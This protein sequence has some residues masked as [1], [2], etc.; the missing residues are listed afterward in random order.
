M[1]PLPYIFFL[2]CSITFGQSTMSLLF[3]GD[4]MGH[5][6]QIEAAFDPSKNDYSYDAVFSELREIISKPDFA[7]ANLEVTLA[8][9]PYSG[10]PQFSSPDALAEACKENGI[11]IL[12]TSNNHSCDRGGKGIKRTIKVLDRL[13]IPHNGTYVNA[14]DRK[15]R[16]LLI[17]RKN[18]LR[19]GLL[20]Y[21][22]GTNGLKAPQPTNVNYIDTNQIRLDIEQSKNESLDGLIAI[23]HWGKEYQTSPNKYQIKIAEFLLR[24]GVNIIIGSHPHVLQKVEWNKEKDQL[25][26]YSLGNFVSNQASI[27]TDGGMMLEIELEK[28]NE[29]L[30]IKNAGY[31]LVWVNKPTRL[32]KKLFEVLPCSSYPAIKQI[33][34]PAHLSKMKIFMESARKIMSSNRNVLEINPAKIKK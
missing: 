18:D 6:S 27:N 28:K 21:T 10:Y 19:I 31:H 29:A 11:D 13:Q 14:V 26:A 12:V 33:K 23:V 9:P 7:I 20:N 15:L 8:G 34:N 22:Y 16:N 32:N 17:L 1:K 25:V 2:T 30:K 24:N 3:I 5:G 4:I